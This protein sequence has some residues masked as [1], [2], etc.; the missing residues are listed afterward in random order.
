MAFT[1]VTLTHPTTN[2]SL[3]APVG[4]SW[5]NFFFGFWV[6][7]LRGDW[8]GFGVMFLLCLV[9]IF[10]WANIWA[11]P[12]YMLLPCLYNRSFIS[13]KIKQGYELH[14]SQDLSVHKLSTVELFPL[15]STEKQ[16][17]INYAIYLA[18]CFVVTFIGFALV[19]A[20]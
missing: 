5:T 15:T 16:N 10:F 1:N 14:T 17:L 20:L 3:T 2:H 18:A 13:R 9:G 7:L 19:A 11:L 12:V 4:F 8:V 6:P